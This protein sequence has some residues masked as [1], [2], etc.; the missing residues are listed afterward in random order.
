MVY[1]GKPSKGCGHCRSRKIRC[2]QLRPAC[3]QCIRTHRECPGYRDQLSLMFRDENKSVLRKVSSTGDADLSKPKRSSTRSLRTAS[4]KR[5]SN[6]IT[7][8]SLSG[9]SASNAAASSVPCANSRDVDLLQVIAGD[10][11]QIPPEIHPSAVPCQ[12]QAISFYLQSN[13]IPGNF[14][15]GDSLVKILNEPGNACKQALQASMTAVASAMM[16]RVRKADSMQQLA[17]KE[18]FSAITLLNS[19]LS[20][21]RESRTNQ[22]LA[23]IILLAI[24]ELITSSA[25]KDV[26]VWT[27][28]IK[29]ATAIL[30]LRG[31][32]QMS[33]ETGRQ[34]F[35]HLRSQIMISC[36]QRDVRLPESIFQ[37]SEFAKAVQP[38]D[39]YVH[40]IAII[41]GRLTCLRADIKAGLVMDPQEI[42]S[43][44]SDIES[45]LNAWHAALPSDVQFDIVPIPQD[46][47]LFLDRCRGL[48][49]Y[50]DLYHLYPSTWAANVWN[51]YRCTRILLSEILLSQI[52]LESE[53]LGWFSDE[54]HWR[55][56]FLQDTIR[57]LSVD[58]C[59]AVPYLLCAHRDF[60]P[61][62]PPPESYMGGMILMWPMF[63]A[64]I[65]EG[66]T[67]PQRLF[68]LRCLRVIGHATGLEQA[69]AVMH[70]VAAD[71]GIL[72]DMTEDDGGLIGEIPGVNSPVETLSPKTPPP[73]SLSITP[74]NSNK[75]YFMAAVHSESNGTMCVTDFDLY[76]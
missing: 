56:Q 67:H 45:E 2:D 21:P 73:N 31:I 26:E 70:I 35:M 17:R 61:D 44:A 39:A 74:V 13:A 55:L 65:V 10:P 62:C 63:L 15:W 14:W 47:Y 30:E 19:A 48:A 59:R 42:I 33:T 68:A 72:N 25:A 36:L 38:S 24:Y 4:L 69:F 49:P 27:N 6:A 34:L 29:G 76:N 37:Y 23:A 66:P 11:W 58:M 20:N 50:D 16:C 8:G 75:N 43:L 12:N 53:A 9:K 52:R 60:S 28:H 57:G 32:E 18:Y 64:G 40:D 71:P 54:A 7:R 46:D 41:T 3:S 51:Q 5:T 22:T 1:C